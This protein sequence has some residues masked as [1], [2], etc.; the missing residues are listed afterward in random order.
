MS[1]CAQWYSLLEICSLIH[2][3]LHKNIIGHTIVT[4]YISVFTSTMWK[5]TLCSIFLFCYLL[6]LV[7]QLSSH[8]ALAETVNSDLLIYVTLL[9][10]SFKVIKFLDSQFKS[11]NL[12]WFGYLS[13]WI[14]RCIIDTNHTIQQFSIFSFTPFTNHWSRKNLN[15]RF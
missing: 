12:M 9:K 14:I 15:E 13:T 6:G 2:S 1:K 5:Q 7:V 10:L 4:C 8:K 3:P 11:Y